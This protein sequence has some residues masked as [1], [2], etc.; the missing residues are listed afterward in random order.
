M[1]IFHIIDIEKTLTVMLNARPYSV[2]VNHP[3]YM[4]VIN[5]LDSEDV[6]RDVLLEMIDPRPA[7]QKFAGSLVEVRGGEV[8][9]NDEPIHNVVVDRIIDFRDQGIPITPLAN[10]LNNLMQNPSYRSRQQLYTF[11]EK[12]KMPITPDGHFMAYKV[13]RDSYLDGHTGTIMHTLGVPISMPRHL[14][15]DDPNHV[16]SAGLHCCSWDYIPRMYPTG[17]ILLMKVN[18]RDVVSVPTDYNNAKMRVCE[19][20]P[21]EEVERSVAEDYFGTSPVYTPNTDYDV[22]QENDDPEDYL[23]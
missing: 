16:C 17:R 8:Y 14:V 20:V 11:L 3:R 9:Y 6:D 22:D 10:F 5:M 1:R 13:V 4:D 2:P 7:I 12:N 21:V 18:P 19:Y 15:D 23:N